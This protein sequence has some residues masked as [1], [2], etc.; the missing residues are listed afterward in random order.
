MR[1]LPS[2]FNSLLLK[3]FLVYLAVSLAM[4]LIPASWTGPL[5]AAVLFPFTAAQGGFLKLLSP[6]EPYARR[7]AAAWRGADETALLRRQ[8][9]E[10]RAQLVLEAERR[11]AAESRLFQIGQLPAEAQQRAVPATLVSYDASALRR[12]AVFDH[13]SEIGIAPNSPVLW[14]GCVIGRVDSVGPWSC[15]AVLLGDRKCRIAVRCARTRDQGMLEGIG[16]GM[17]GVLFIPVAAD[18]RVGDIFVTSG[19][20]GIFPTGLLIGDCTEV[21]SEAGAIHKWVVVKPAFDPAS[22]EHVAILLPE[23]K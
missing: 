8:T 19:V 17:S 12:T 10:L 7:A 6:L 18:V 1:F 13:G 9:A 16:G 20:D 22:L 21:S 23:A 3:T 11:H 5:R 14:K 4:L 15:R 2:R